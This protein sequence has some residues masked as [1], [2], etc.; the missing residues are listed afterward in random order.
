MM[1]ICNRHMRSQTG[2]GNGFCRRRRH[3]EEKEPRSLA[4]TIGAL[5]LWDV[6]P[7]GVR[8]ADM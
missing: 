3:Q 8:R 4:G 7:D 1:N 6:T 5:T 2:Q